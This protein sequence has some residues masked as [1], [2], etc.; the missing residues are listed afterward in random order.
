MSFVNKDYTDKRDTILSPECKTNAINTLRGLIIERAFD[1]IVEKYSIAGL[2][3]G[4][5]TVTAP[6][7]G[8]IGS[9]KELLTLSFIVEKGEL[10]AYKDRYFTLEVNIKDEGILGE[11]MEINLQMYKV[12]KSL[13]SKITVVINA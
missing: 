10:T 12:A 11:M 9:H 1:S 4:G 8:M 6:S 2:E 7:F 3:F 13:P 5:Y